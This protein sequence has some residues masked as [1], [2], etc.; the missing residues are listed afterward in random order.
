MAVAIVVYSADRVRAN[1]IGRSLG[2]RRREAAV[3]ESFYPAREAVLKN[4]PDF[5]IYESLRGSP[6]EWKFF[7]SFAATHPQTEILYLVGT[8]RKAELTAAGL[9]AKACLAEELDPERI[10]VLAEERIRA[11]EIAQAPPL[12]KSLLISRGKIRKTVRKAVRRIPL[13]VALVLGAGVGYVLWSM[14]GLPRVELLGE[15]APLEASKVYSQDNVLLTE[16]YLERRTFLSSDRIPE[17]VKAAFLAAED[18]RFYSHVGIDPVRLVRAFIENIKQGGY[19]QGGSTITQQ[20][21][22]MLFLKPEKSIR[23]KIQEIALALKIERRYTKDEILGLYLN[24]TYFGTRAYGLEAAAQTYFGKTAADLTIAE[25]AVLAAL[26]KAPSLYSPFRNPER[27]RER[28]DYVLMR[29]LK[30]GAITAAEYEAAV[31]TA[32]PEVFHAPIRKAPYF[33]DYC[34]SELEDK[35][36]SR[37]QTAG[38]EIVTTLDYRIQEKAEYAVAEGMEDLRARGLDGLQ[39]ALVALELGSGRIL[40]MVGGTDY[41]ESQFNRATLARRQPG[42]IFKPFVYLAALEKGFRPEGAIVY[43]RL[44]PVDAETEDPESPSNGN[45]D[46]EE[47]ETVAIPLRVALAHSLNGPTVTLAYQVGLRTVFSTAR[48]LGIKSEIRPFVSSVLGASEATLLE[49]VAAYATLATS[50]R[51]NPVSIDRVIDRTRP[52][53]WKPQPQ[54]EDVLEPDVRRGICSLLRA[55]ILEGTGAPAGVLGRPVYG[56]TGTTNDAADA[57]FVGFDDRVAVGVWVGRD[58]RAPIGPEEEGRTAALPIWIAFMR[59]LEGL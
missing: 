39:A 21:A 28:R 29:L 54:G 16:Y 33:L 8:A 31:V 45:G 3:F 37:L 38:L 59:N 53:V 20:L 23:R 19:V 57:W 13:A 52:S 43:K 18:K 49:Y 2:Q 7:R 5:L 46:G 40:A 51:Q 10:M 50:V 15:Y 47:T 32:V 42:S 34:R 48:R 55:V 30:N 9:S 27:C 58:S 11:I 1:I 26:P 14:S 25:A 4:P 24:Q 36:G 41:A 35:F 12:R 17:R 6:T 44:R 56:K 22:R